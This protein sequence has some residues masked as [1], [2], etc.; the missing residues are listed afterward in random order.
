M[1]DKIDVQ[2]SL[3]QAFNDI[4]I[5]PRPKILILIGEEMRKEEPDFPFLASLIKRDVL[6][7]A[8][9]IKTANSPALGT[10][11]RIR[12][13]NEAMLMLGLRVVSNTIAGLIFKNLFPPTAELDRYWDASERT[14]ELSGWIVQRLDIRKNISSDDAYTFSLFRDC[15]IPILLRRFPDYKD[16]LKTANDDELHTFTEVEDE[17]FPTNHTVIGARM[18]QSWD[19]PA[20]FVLGIKNHHDPDFYMPG[21]DPSHAASQ[22]YVAIAQLAEWLHQKVT[23]N[24]HTME[25]EKLGDKCLAILGIEAH[26]AEGMLDDA[27]DILRWLKVF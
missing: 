5:P 6:L 18:V 20:E 14:A 3:E 8:G 9:L 7:S 15:G 24:N 26:V 27:G 23:Y 4:E 13:V 12:S 25:W 17:Y 22:K 16:V 1:A 19:M 2:N 10:T 21:R 11:R